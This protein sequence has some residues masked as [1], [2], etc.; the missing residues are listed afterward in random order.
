MFEK[1][2]VEKKDLEE[3][4]ATFLGA[5]A[6]QKTD[7]ENKLSEISS[8]KEQ[9]LLVQEKSCIC[10]LGTKTGYPLPQEISKAIMDEMKVLM[11]KY[12]LLWVTALNITKKEALNFLG[13]NSQ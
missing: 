12:G 13:T 10:F 11:E 1:N 5:L 2:K 4:S 3:L 7:F 9:E 8:K 6:Q